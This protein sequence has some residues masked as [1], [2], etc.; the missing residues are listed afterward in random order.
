[1]RPQRVY[2]IKGFNVPDITDDDR[3]A[4]LQSFVLYQA[5]GFYRDEQH[6]HTAQTFHSAAIQMLRQLDLV[7]MINK[8]VVRSADGLVGPELNQAWKDWVKIE[9]RRRVAAITYLLD[10]EFAT[11]FKVEPKLAF[12]ELD[13][14]LPSAEVLWKANTPAEWQHVQA[15]PIIPPNIHFLTAVR[16]LLA[17]DH[18]NPFSADNLL[19]SE[20]GRLDAFPLLILTRTLTFLQAKAEDAL[21][22]ADPFRSMLGGLMQ[23]QQESSAEAELLRKIRRGK[24]YLRSLP[25]GI[26]RGSGEGWFEEALP[27]ASVGKPPAE[28]AVMTPELLKAVCRL[29][30]GSFS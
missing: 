26:Q 10:L 7:G 19:L 25:G 11:Y 13:I 24:D 29:S 8:A 23:N 30:F 21:A 1:M 15:S 16:A 20:L 17:I 14:G 2:L 9:T 18:S 28:S 22:K 4:Y 3:F 5:V 27:T 6:R 12:S